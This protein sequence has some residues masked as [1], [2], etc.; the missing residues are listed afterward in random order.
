MEYVFR[1]RNCC[2]LCG[3]DGDVVVSTGLGLGLMWCRDCRMQELGIQDS[4][5]E[6]YRRYD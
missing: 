5:D 3:T 2:D 6:R 1:L 4:D